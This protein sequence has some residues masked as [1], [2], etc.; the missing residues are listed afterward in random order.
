MPIS[1]LEDKRFIFAA[2]NLLSVQDFVSGLASYLF[3]VSS[4]LE[5]DNI[6]IIDL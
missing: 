4:Y 1:G 5:N 2:T 6:P 3:F